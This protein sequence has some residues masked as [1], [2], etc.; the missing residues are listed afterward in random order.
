MLRIH[1]VALKPI[2]S[3]AL[4]WLPVIGILSALLGISFYLPL[5]A[6]YLPLDVA[7]IPGLIA[8]C[9]LRGF[10]PEIERADAPSGG[11]LKLLF[12]SD[13]DFALVRRG[14]LR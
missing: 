4:A 12:K 8:L 7:I 14:M 11:G 1:R 2:D 9:W 10:K 5:A 13:A 6:L 3:S